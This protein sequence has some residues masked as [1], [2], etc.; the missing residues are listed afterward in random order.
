MTGKKILL[1]QQF[2]VQE[3]SEDAEL[4]ELTLRS[5]KLG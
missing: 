5:G 1:F 2:C 3:F 4:Q